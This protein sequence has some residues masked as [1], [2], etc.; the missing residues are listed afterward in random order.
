MREVYARVKTWGELLEEGY[1]QV[2][3]DDVFSNDG[4]IL[5][6]RGDHVCSFLFTSEHNK[7]SNKKY[8]FR[9]I[10]YRLSGCEVYALRG[11]KKHLKFSIDVIEVLKTF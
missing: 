11:L 10:N 2:T 6:K 5:K 7:Y 3:I 4:E 9:K 1:E 8:V